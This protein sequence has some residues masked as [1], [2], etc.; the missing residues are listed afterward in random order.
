MAWVVITTT[1]LFK[2]ID[3]TLGLRVTEEE[4]VVGLDKLEHGLTS[5]YADF[6][7]ASTVRKLKTEAEKVSVD[8]V[9]PVQLVSKSASSDVIAS[10]IKL[11]KIEII[12]DQ[13]KFKNLKD[14]LNEIGIMGMTVSN[15]LGCGTQ[16]GAPKY[17]RG[18]AVE[19]ECASMLAV[20]KYRHIPFIQFLYGADNLSSDTWEIRDLNLF[21]LNNAEK[22]MVLAFECVLAM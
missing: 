10:D 5:A 19:M 15:V 8:K 21:G 17:Y 12:T 1:I 6:A 7:K 11:T 18:I 13:D 20:A 16:K 9:V 14:A 22:Y 3:A 4:E 2:A